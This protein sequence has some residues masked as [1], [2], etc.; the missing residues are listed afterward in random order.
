LRIWPLIG[1]STLSPSNVPSLNVP[2]PNFWWI[3]YEPNHK[4]W[5]FVCWTLSSFY[6]SH[7]RTRYTPWKCLLPTYDLSNQFLFTSWCHVK[8]ILAFSLSSSG[9]N[10]I[11]NLSCITRKALSWIDWASCREGKKVWVWKV[12]SNPYTINKG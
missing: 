10:N 9:F 11:F 2:G 1:R 4:F 6:F 12:A 7:L 3:R 8:F 5:N